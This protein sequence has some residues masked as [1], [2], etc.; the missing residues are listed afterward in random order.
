MTHAPVDRSAVLLLVKQLLVKLSRIH[1]YKKA[2]V[3][4]IKKPP[5][6]NGEVGFLIDLRQEFFRH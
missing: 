3:P 5:P 6:P 2:L 1:F 4:I